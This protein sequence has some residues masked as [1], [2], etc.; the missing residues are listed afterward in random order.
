M[1]SDFPQSP[2]YIAA[3]EHGCWPDGNIRKISEIYPMRRT[4]I[5]IAIPSST[6]LPMRLFS[7]D[8]DLL[9]KRTLV[10]PICRE[11]H[12]LSK[13]GVSALPNNFCFDTIKQVVPKTAD[14]EKCG[15]GIDSN[16]A[17]GF[18]YDCECCLC[19]QCLYS[20]RK[21][22]ATC[23]HTTVSLLEKT[24]NGPHRLPTCSKHGAELK[25]YCYNCNDA[26]CC[27]CAI[28]DPHRLHKYEYL[29]KVASGIYQRLP[30]LLV[31]MNERQEQLKDKVKLFQADWKYH[32]EVNGAAAIDKAC[33]A[34]IKIVDARRTS[35]LEEW[36]SKS[37]GIKERVEST[38]HSLTKVSRAANFIKELDTTTKSD[39][40]LVTMLKPMM[41]NFE[42]LHSATLSL[43]ASTKNFRSDVVIEGG[44]MNQLAAQLPK[45]VTLSDCDIY[46][47]TPE[48]YQHNITIQ[49]IRCK[50]AKTISLDEITVTLKSGSTVIPTKIT[51]EQKNY[52][53]VEFEP[54]QGNQKYLLNVSI[55]GIECRTRTFQYKYKH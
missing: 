37:A 49:I 55:L 21:M 45:I 17:V 13:I 50:V 1:K 39:F 43:Q 26:V 9:R 46:V 2:L 6:A 5:P 28:N 16:S 27:E 42:E 36:K 24:T 38:K 30:E 32:S 35:L 18:C 33:D 4:S 10:C 23:K 3:L 15:N 40:E 14:G 52:W 41:C 31:M 22:V 8:R 25:L 7:Y 20:H 12:Q 11:K 29:D 47:I 34:I 19:Q 51:S 48:S 53:S 54:L 44:D